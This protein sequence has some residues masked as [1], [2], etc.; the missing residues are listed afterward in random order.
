[1]R[2]VFAAID[3][4]VMSEGF[5]ASVVC[6]VL[7]ASRSGFYAWRSDAASRREQRDREL[8]PLIQEIFWRHKR[9]YGARRITAELARRNIAVGVARVARLLKTQGLRAIQPKSFTPKTTQSRHRLGYNDNLLGPLLI[10][11]LIP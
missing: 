8:M 2:N 3:Q 10:P 11:L 6:D 7:K 5:A 1:M 4:I 9:R